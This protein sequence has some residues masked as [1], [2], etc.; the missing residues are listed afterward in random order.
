MVGK[1]LTKLCAITID[2]PVAAGKTVVGSLVARHLDWRFLDTGVMYRAVAWAAMQKKVRIDDETGLGELARSL[3]IE[4]V[5]DGPGKERLLLYG[6]DITAH[7]RSREVENYVSLVARVP[8]VRLAM[9]EKQRALG[10]EG[11]IV[12]AGRDIGT[13][14]LP[15]A[16]VK[17]FLLASVEERAKRRFLEMRQKGM[18]A[19]YE[20]VLEDLKRRDKIDTERPLSPLKAAADA[21]VV[22]T[23]GVEVQRVVDKILS[24]ARG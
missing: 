11:K 13:V 16:R 21:I 20:Q 1:Y 2:G 15:E 6:Q 7:L 4:L 3:R 10:K 18:K 23:D 5:S 24:I 22:E 19:S 12:M 8:E 17:I 14:V 9:V